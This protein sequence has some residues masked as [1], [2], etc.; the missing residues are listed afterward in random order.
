MT[1]TQ[2]SRRNH[3]RFKQS[4]EYSR[5]ESA[6]IQAVRSKI[7]FEKNKLLGYPNKL[8]DEFV[9]EG[10]LTESQ[11]LTVNDYVRHCMKNWFVAAVEARCTVETI[12]D[13]DG[14]SDV[15]DNHKSTNCHCH[16]HR[17]THRNN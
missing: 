10:H 3:K 17:Y 14:A 8:Y 6:V 1:R 15:E 16:T 2:S 12:R 9:N 11:R 13:D 7:A 5:S 4:S